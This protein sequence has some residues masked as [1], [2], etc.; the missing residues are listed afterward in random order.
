[1]PKSTKLMFAAGIVGILLTT[2]GYAQ[3]KAAEKAKEPTG[4][5][6]ALNNTKGN[7]L[8]CHLLPGDPKAVT[9]ANIA[10]PLIAMKARFPDKNK[11]RDQIWDATKINPMSAMPPFGKHQIL[12]EQE[13]DKVTDYVY[14]L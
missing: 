9:S 10:P 8:A 4:Q 14:G 12:T 7:C 13:I 5:D 3:D 1:M 2:T 11:L 6:I